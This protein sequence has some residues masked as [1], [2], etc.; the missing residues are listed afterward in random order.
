MIEVNTKLLS[1]VVLSSLV[2][3]VDIVQKVE[4]ACTAETEKQERA[5]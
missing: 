3:Y 4:V 2:V 5:M 1:G